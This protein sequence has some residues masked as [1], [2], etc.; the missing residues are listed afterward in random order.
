[1]C[2]AV[3]AQ[4]S[5]T[6]PPNTKITPLGPQAH[7]PPGQQQV[8]TGTIYG[9]VYWDATLTS[10]L[11]PSVCNAMSITV[12][13]ASK[14]PY[15][16]FGAMGTQSHF[17][18]MATAHPPVLSVNTTS[19]DGC[20]YSYTNAPLGQNL[21]VKLNLTQ[22][23]GQLLPATV[24]QNPA[25]G[26]IQF[27]NAPCSTL[28]PLTKATV[29]NLLGSWGS[30]QNVAYDVNLPLIIL[31]PL[32]ILS[33]SGGAGGNQSATPGTRVQTNPG[34]INNPAAV[35]PGPV[36]SSMLSQ[37]G[38]QTTL[39]NTQSPTSSQSGGMLVPAVTPAPLS[40]Y[41]TQPGTPGQLL[42]AKPGGGGATVQ[43]NPQP[44]PPKGTSSSPAGSAGF[45]GGINSSATGGFTGGVRPALLPALTGGVKVIPGRR[46]RNALAANSLSAVLRQ[47]RQSSVPVSHTLSA[48]SLPPL[49]AQ[50]SNARLTTI[51]AMYVP[52]N[53]LTPKQNAWCKLSEAQGG[54]PTIFSVAGK[55]QGQ[56]LVYSPD[57]Q[58]NPY[59]IVGCGFGNSPGTVQ[60]QLLQ[61][62]PVNS[63]WFNS[64]G[65]QTSAVYTIQCTIQNWSDHQIV[66][67]IAP[68]TS[69]VPDWSFIGL[70]VKTRQAGYAA[71]GQF[72]ALRNTVLL[73]N[74]PQKQ[75]S[76]YQAGS[77]YF[78]S[79]VSNYY[80][81]NGT[82]AVMRQ[83]LA[84]PVAGQDQFSLNLSAG[85]VVDSTQTDLLVA[86]TASNVT[87]QLANLNGSTITVTYPVLSATSGNSTNYYSIYGLK[88]WVT[89]PQGIDP[90][91]G[92]PGP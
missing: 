76:L 31:K 49:A 8:M 68:N 38:S 52:S 34:P 80:G 79:P 24:A 50:P 2:G 60:L 83:G 22:P 43:L 42:P 66:A 85:F 46:V 4:I 32:K 9:F 48:S 35:S 82:V 11:G 47:Q 63:G 33:A 65:S 41:N 16:P 92:K 30:C 23:L 26:P 27:N 10:L 91:T 21:Y 90:W 54:P 88:V 39:L 87:P 74:I 17:T 71:G 12:A 62:Q 78:L 44:Y 18:P 28:P 20:A 64:Q 6:K 81:L 14:S 51:S 84:G 53:L 70:Q 58:A 89:G 37:T 56:N 1:M 19:Y 45:V 73:A 29:G 67:S 61:S 77:P 55:N 59:T 3:S 72:V 75:V 25:V 86:N 13:V 7:R 69:G 15:S 40:S 5:A 36:Q 57:P